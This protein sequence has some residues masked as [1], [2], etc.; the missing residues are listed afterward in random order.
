MGTDAS[1][2]KERNQDVDVII[3]GPGNDTAH[4]TDEYV[5]LD[6]FYSFIRLYKQIAINYLK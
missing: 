3:L 6:S 4:Q 1:Q 5:D 2:F